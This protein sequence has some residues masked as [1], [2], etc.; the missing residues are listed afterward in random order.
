[1]ED[2]II[3]GGGPAGLY[4]AFYCGLRGMSVKLIEAQTYL[5]GK[6]NVY[7]EK[8]IWDIGGVVP[9]PAEDIVASLITQANAFEPTYCLGTK[10]IGIFREG[11]NFC[12]HTDDGEK[13]Y[14]KSVILGTGTGII[15]PK[16]LEFDYLT[17][18]ETSNLHYGVS[19]IEAFRNRKIM[20]TGGNDSAI[21]WAKILADVAEKVYL[22]YRKDLFRG[23]E[24]EVASV[25]NH[26]KIDCLMEKKITNF[27]TLDN[28]TIHSAEIT[29][30]MEETIEEIEIDD[31]IVCHGFEKNN[32]LTKGESAFELV[33]G[34]FYK[35][36]ENG[37]TTVDGVFAAGD[38]ASY[39]GKVRLIAGAFHDAV[40]ATNHAKKRIDPEATDTGQVSSH[41]D[42]LQKR[43]VPTA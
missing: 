14:A 30:V 37:E 42:V 27:T 18:F 17:D 4:S 1:M 13:H 31:V 36:T 32:P 8:N 28:Q 11:E 33:D 35:T 20:I 40:N 24:A 2:V 26:D 5:G 23:Y 39:D 9:Q 38:A 15:T 21:Q 34:L 3:V 41:H 22:V 43:E 25:L 12:V 16:K 7:K 19:S 10:V 29:H 6:L